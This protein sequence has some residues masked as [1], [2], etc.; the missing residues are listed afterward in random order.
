MVHEM[1]SDLD[2]SCFKIRSALRNTKQG[3]FLVTEY[4]NTLWQKMD[5]F[6]KVD[7][8]C[9]KNSL[10]I[11]KC[12]TKSRFLTFLIAKIKKMDER[13]RPLGIKPFQL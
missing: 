13:G 8:H 5:M 3:N 11:S 1:Y 4:F 12:L 2:N 7:W 9:A 6:N 10:N